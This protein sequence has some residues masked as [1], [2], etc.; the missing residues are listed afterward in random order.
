M[1]H[2]FINARLSHKT[3]TLGGTYEYNDNEKISFGKI[4]SLDNI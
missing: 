2:K 4:I 1:F 3:G